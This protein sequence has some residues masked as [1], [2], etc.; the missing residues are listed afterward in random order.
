MSALAQFADS[1]R[2][3]LEVREVPEAALSICSKTRYPTACL[4]DHLVGGDLQGLGNFH[5]E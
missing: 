4:F 1:S 3:Y 2:T 5:T